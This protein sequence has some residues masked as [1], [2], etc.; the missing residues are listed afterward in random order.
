MWEKAGGIVKTEENIIFY[1][2]KLYI[3]TKIKTKVHTKA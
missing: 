2:D 1:T 3:N